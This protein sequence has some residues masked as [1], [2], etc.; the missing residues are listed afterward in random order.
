MIGHVK[1]RRLLSFVGDRSYIL[2]QTCGCL[3]SSDALDLYFLLVTVILLDGVLY[4]IF[5]FHDVFRNIIDSVFP[6]VKLYRVGF[7]LGHSLFLV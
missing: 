5:I 2:L 6:I 3:G 7:R 1:S 4:V